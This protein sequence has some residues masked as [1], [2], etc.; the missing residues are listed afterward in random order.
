M[1]ASVMVGPN[2]VYDAEDLILT[3][4][5]GSTSVRYYLSGIMRRLCDF[6]LLCNGETFCC[7]GFNDES[8]QRKR[9]RINAV[10]DL[11][12]S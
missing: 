2:N 1:V 4:V 7:S 11:T 10:K 5:L 8:Y 6:F 12:E 3:L 9:V